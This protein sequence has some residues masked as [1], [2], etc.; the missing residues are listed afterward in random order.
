ML[1]YFAD[2]IAQTSSMCASGTIACFGAK[3]FSYRVIVEAPIAFFG[4]VQ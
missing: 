3:Y 2:S 4:A 1:D